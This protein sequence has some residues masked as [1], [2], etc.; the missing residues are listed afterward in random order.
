MKKKICAIIAIS[1]AIT[2]ICA[3]RASDLERIGMLESLLY[4]SLSL[5]GLIISTKIGGFMQ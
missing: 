5:A 2:L 3:A 4:G 1:C